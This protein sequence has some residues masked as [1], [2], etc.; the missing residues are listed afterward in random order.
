MTLTTRTTL[1]AVLA[2]FLLAFALL[3]MSLPRP[4]EAHR[5]GC[6]RSH[7]CPSDHATYRW[8]QQSTGAMLLCVAPYAVERDSSF[9]KRVVYQGRTYW[10]KRST[11]SGGAARCDP[12]YAGACLDPNASDYDCAGGSGNGPKYVGRVQV[13]G[14][15]HYGLDADGDGIGCE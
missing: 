11:S 5:S 9:R 3:A 14:S 2:G 7:S 8:R 4:A 10:C 1:A 13:V 6:H 15:D 12:N